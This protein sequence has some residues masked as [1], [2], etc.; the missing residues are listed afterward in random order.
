M[1]IWSLH[2]ALLDSKGLVA[3]W[4][5][6]LLAQKVMQGLTKGYKNHP[7]LERFKAHSEPLAAITTYLHGLADEADARGYKFDRSRIVLEASQNLSKIPVTTGQLE[8]ELEFLR[9]KVQGRDPYWF[10]E[11]IKDIQEPK[12]HPVFI[13]CRG[14]SNSG[15]K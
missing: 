1:R 3:C 7:Q 4:R 12:T 9:L 2:P 11:K 8:Y 10:H 15:K 5:E 13:N 6:T 14:T